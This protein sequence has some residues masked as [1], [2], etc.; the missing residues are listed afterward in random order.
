MDNLN[1]IGID[2]AKNVI[3]IYG[4]D[5]KGKLIIKKRLKR[6]NFLAFMANLP[7]CLIGME[8]CAG[9][10]Y[11]AKQLIKLGFPVK[12]MSPRKVKKFVENNKNDEKDAKACAE[13]VTR[14]DMTFVPIKTDEQLEMQAI[15]RVRSYYVR[16][17]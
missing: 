14:A 15:H 16:Q 13:A 17:N 5:S 1:V 7:N 12:L 6:D 10:H 3:Q 2:I 4:T 8:A 9:A 11:W